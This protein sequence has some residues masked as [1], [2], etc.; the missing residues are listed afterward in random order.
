VNKTIEKK[1]QTGNQNKNIHN[2][3]KK[4]KNIHISDIYL[5]EFVYYTDSH[6]ISQKKNLKKK[7]NYD[8]LTDQGSCAY[9][10]ISTLYV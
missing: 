6:F 5:N 8:M 10:F 9:D 2:L 3:E 7:K 1:R 4:K